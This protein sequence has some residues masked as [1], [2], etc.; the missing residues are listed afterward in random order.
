MHRQDEDRYNEA[1][2]LTHLGDNSEAAGRTSAARSH[3]RRALTILTD[4]GH[5]S[6]EDLR[7]RLGAP[8]V[9]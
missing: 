9:D 8:D 1:L 3:W 2:V 6:A 4:L 7:A 5:P